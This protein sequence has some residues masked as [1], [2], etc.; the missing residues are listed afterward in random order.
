MT[1]TRGENDENR[2]AARDGG[3]PSPTLPSSQPTPAH[4]TGSPQPSPL[5]PERARLRAAVLASP[6]AWAADLLINYG[7]VRR[8]SVH[9]TKLPVLITTAVCLATMGAAALVCGRHLRSHPTSRPGEGHAERRGSEAAS[10]TLAHDSDRTLALWGLV[11][12]VYFALLVLGQA[13]PALV[14]RA[15]ELAG[16]NSRSPA[17]TL[18]AGGPTQTCPFVPLSPRGAPHHE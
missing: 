12:A 11:L 10:A 14:L 13:Y 15:E 3:G 5:P 1:M 7:F 6:L 18:A 4:P 17:L 8:M 2:G 9:G 16:R